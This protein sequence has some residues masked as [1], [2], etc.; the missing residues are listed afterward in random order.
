MNKI[1]NQ[2]IILWSHKNKKNNQT[3][4]LKQTLSFYYIFKFYSHSI[5]PAH[6]LEIFGVLFI[7][8]IKLFSF[9]VKDII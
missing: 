7:N 9:L 1:N 5:I 2:R 3:N 6:L 4:K 8:F